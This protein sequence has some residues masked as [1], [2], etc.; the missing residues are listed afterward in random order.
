[1]CLFNT[2]QHYEE[3]NNP[4]VDMNEQNQRIDYLN[5][6]R[7]HN[8]SNITAPHEAEYECDNRWVWD[9]Q[10]GNSDHMTINANHNL[11]SVKVLLELNDLHYYSPE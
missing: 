5:M 7:P 4:Y 1:M 8:Y 11:L 6:M 3:L 9:P 10:T 2:L